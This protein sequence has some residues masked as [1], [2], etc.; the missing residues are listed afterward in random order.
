MSSR[1]NFI[2]F[3]DRFFTHVV[4]ACNTAHILSDPIKDCLGTMPVSLIEATAEEAR[5][6][7]HKRLGLLASP[8]T[9]KSGLFE[10]AL[11]PHG[12]KM[13]LPNSTTMSEIEAMIRDTIAGNTPSC[14]SLLSVTQ[15]LRAQGAERVILGCTELSVIGQEIS[16]DVV[17]DP[18]KI[19]VQRIFEEVS[20]G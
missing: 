3:G 4:I 11:A 1:D 5:A 6:R 8:T 18:L 19:V 16:E 2:I 15:A 13:I 14:E 7:R 17:I 12:I 20:H 9:I 10:R